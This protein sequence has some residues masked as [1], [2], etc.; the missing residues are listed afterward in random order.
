MFSRAG[1]VVGA[2][3]VLF[4]PYSNLRRWV[5]LTEINWE[6]KISSSL[7]QLND[8]VSFAPRS[9][10]QQG[11]KPLVRT[12]GLYVWMQRWGGYEIYSQG[13][14]WCKKKLNDTISICHCLNIIYIVIIF[15]KFNYNY[16]LSQ[17]SSGYKNH[18][19]FHFFIQSVEY[20]LCVEFPTPH[21][22]KLLMGQKW[23]QPPWS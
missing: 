6:S 1:T 13:H 11:L 20:L 15:S 14:C 19:F 4:Y 16:Y 10:W 9:S 3:C 8:R 18:S 2:V 7:R 23:R 5:Y 21:P 12:Q 17:S 22:R